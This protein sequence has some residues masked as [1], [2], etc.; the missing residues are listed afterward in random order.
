M[1]HTRF[2]LE[3]CLA[4]LKLS[5]WGR[6]LIKERINMC[7]LEESLLE[8]NSFLQLTDDHEKLLVKFSTISENLMVLLS[9]VI[10]S[11]F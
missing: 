9:N 11:D 7:F 10:M 1:E 5:H 8:R 3:Y 6:G 2:N 4:D